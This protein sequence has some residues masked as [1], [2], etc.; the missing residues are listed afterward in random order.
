MLLAL[1]WRNI[2]RNT[3]R[4]LITVVA[5]GLGVV[6]IVFLHSYR[7]CTYGEMVRG[8]TAG[9]VGHIQVHGK[10]YQE[11][12]AVEVV[13]K[14]PVAV[15]ARLTSA[16][17][18]AKVERRVLGAGL[19]GAGE[20]SSPVM[21][22]GMEPPKEA[23]GTLATVVTGRQLAGAREVVLGKDLARD[24]GL[25]P[26]GE[27]VLVGQ[28]VDGSVANDRYTVVGTAD[29]GSSEMNAGAVFMRLADAQA[30]FGL[31]DGVHQIIV[32]LPTDQ[33]DLTPEVATLRA[34]LD[35][36]TLEALSWAEM[37]P[38]LRTTM[39]EKRSRQHLVDVIVFLIVALGVLNAMTMS[40]F[41]RTHELG[42]MAA[43][44]TRRGRLLS[45]IMTEAFLQAVVGFAAGLA[46]ATALLYGIGEVSLSGLSQQDMMG[47][48]FPEKVVLGLRSM[49]VLSA[50]V[51]AFATALLGALVPA[52]RASRLEPVDAMRHT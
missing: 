39:A 37:L 38:E 34:A 26:G 44:G 46:A 47:A 40:T 19:A 28:A 45:L 2:W 49:A 52:W 41:E 20:Q 42:V 8:I 31:E 3:R 5:L 33:E 6:G 15:E 17:P 13:V 48:K 4:T 32:R 25:E 27:L 43:L 10:G 1:A 12:P 30:F 22:V 35:L 21:V 36:A 11:A 18:F 9:L 51:T 50:A 29:S 23:A 16:L 14:D 7:E 24:L